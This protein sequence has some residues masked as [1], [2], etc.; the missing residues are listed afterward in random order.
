M[1]GVKE[2]K[3]LVPVRIDNAAALSLPEIKKAMT[4]VVD[5]ARREEYEDHAKKMA[6]NK[7]YPTL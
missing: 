2:G 3:D 4:P 6:P 5:L 1:I 7:I